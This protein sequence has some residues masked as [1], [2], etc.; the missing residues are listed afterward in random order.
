[1]LEDAHRMLLLRQR[2]ARAQTIFVDD[3][4]LARLDV[5][6]IGRVDQIECAGF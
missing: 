4:H 6:H 3:D 1:M 5:A 2:M